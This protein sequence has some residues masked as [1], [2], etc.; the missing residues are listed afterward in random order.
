MLLRSQNLILFLTTQYT[1]APT[2]PQAHNPSL[3]H[4]F[5]SSNLP[6]LNV[7]NH[8]LHHS[9]SFPSKLTTITEICYQPLQIFN[10]RSIFFHHAV[11][12]LFI[13]IIF[14]VVIL[15]LLPFSFNTRICRRFFFFNLPLLSYSDSRNRFKKVTVSDSVSG[16]TR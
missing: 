13:I 15:F 3:T 16:N 7:K 2:R 11:A 10:A 12:F 8:T 6:I 14:I 9:F 1:S 4:T 5:G